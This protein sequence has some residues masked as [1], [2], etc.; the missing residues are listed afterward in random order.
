MGRERRSA[1]RV[2]F[3]GEVLALLPQR[4]VICKGINLSTGGM[5]IRPSSSVTGGAFLRVVF[6]LPD[7]SGKLQPIEAGTLVVREGG[8]WAL[9]FVQLSP[10]ALA[11]IARFVEVGLGAAPRR[12]RWDADAQGHRTIV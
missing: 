12:T 9:K 6:S 4:A 11:L 2:A 8:A 3:G 5:L 7:A 1:P 10:T